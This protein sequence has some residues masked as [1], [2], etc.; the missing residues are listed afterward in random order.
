MEDKTTPKISVIMPVFNGA[1]YIEK[2]INS[3]LVQS[4]QDW[5]F[6]VVD[7]GSTDATPRILE[8]YTD[9]RIRIIRQKNGGEANA[10]NTGLDNMR[11]EY[12]AFLD[13]DDVYFPNALKDL[14][15][16]LDENSGY[17][18]VF[19]DGQ[20]CDQE[21]RQL[22]RLTE[23]RPGVITGNILDAL[24]M[25]P[26]VITVPVCTMSRISEIREHDLHFDEE[27]NLIGTDWDFW[28]RLAVH[29]EF[30]YLDKLTC[31]YRIHT[32]NLTRTTGFEKRRKDNIYRRM[33]ILNS[34]WFDT[35]SL[36]TKQLFFLDLLTGALSDDIERQRQ[37]LENEKFLALPASVRS[38][39]WRSVGIDILQ[40]DKNIEFAR[41]C[42][43][44]SLNLQPGSLKTRFLLWGTGMGRPFVLAFIKIWRLLLQIRKRF[45][46]PRHSPSMR[47]QKLLGIQ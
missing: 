12:L 27:N 23:V 38:F 6:I 43:Q 30:G 28:I 10:R 37:V 17:G 18:V 20:I 40:N 29:V 16:F 31:K 19:S 42:F 44:E 39:L 41:P 21:D 46:S 34:D 13:A 32:A 7:D 8:Q 11:G 1:F 35:L 14:S 33:K 45:A 9:P 25:T 2:A 24:V 22:M 5:E 26:S 3:L 15:Q 4:F 47:L 36:T